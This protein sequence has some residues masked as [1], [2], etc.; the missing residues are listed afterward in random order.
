MRN[1]EGRRA[2]VAALGHRNVAEAGGIIDERP[3]FLNFAHAVV[4]CPKIIAVGV[5]DGGHRIIFVRYTV[6]SPCAGESCWSRGGVYLILI[7][8]AC[9]LTVECR[10]VD[11]IEGG[12]YYIVVFQRKRYCVISRFNV[13]N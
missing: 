6:T 9:F 8:T 10:G 4:N 3:F 12:S 5:L 13:F 11:D 7:P 2:A 1:C